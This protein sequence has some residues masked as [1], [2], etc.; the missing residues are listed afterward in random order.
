MPWRRSSGTEEEEPAPGASSRSRRHPRRRLPGLCFNVDGHLPMPRNMPCLSLP[1]HTLSS[2]FNI[3]GR[4]ATPRDAPCPLSKGTHRLRPSI[5]MVAQQSRPETPCRLPCTRLTSL[6]SS[7]WMDEFPP[8]PENTVPSAEDTHLSSPSI[9]MRALSHAEKTPRK[10][11]EGARVCRRCCSSSDSRHRQ[12]PRIRFCRTI[13]V[14]TGK[15][16]S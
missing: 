10:Y 9:W 13:P 3:D 6:L 14:D 8:R 5:W 12:Y 11:R 1:R 2:F 16:A 7:I 4:L 15:R